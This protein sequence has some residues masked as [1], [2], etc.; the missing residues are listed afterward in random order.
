MD[1]DITIR[2]T[3]VG[4]F[5]PVSE[6][7]SEARDEIYKL[8]SEIER[9][10]KKCDTQATM[11]RSIDPE[12]FPDTLFIHMYG[13]KKDYNGMPERLY[14]VPAHGVDFSYV[15]ENTG[16]TTGPEW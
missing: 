3:E 13:G 8:R 15:Y 7:C 11:L 10:K 1:R 14:V 12:K 16:K 9:L 2:L 4:G 5:D 6:L